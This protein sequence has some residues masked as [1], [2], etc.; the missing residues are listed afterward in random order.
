[1]IIY[2]KNDGSTSC[3]PSSI[4]FGSSLQEVTVIVPSMVATIT[5]RIKPPNA[6][7]LQPFICTPTFSGEGSVVFVA[8]LE[9][10]MANVSGRAEYQV[11]AI[12]PEGQRMTFELGTF[13][14][15][16][17]VLADIPET[18]EQLQDYNVD[19]LYEMLSNVTMVY[20]AFKGIEALVGVGEELETEAKTIIEAINEINGK[21]GIAVQLPI[22]EEVSV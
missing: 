20:E 5:L 17:G 19:A 21:G 4:P 1:M 3:F 8:K 15:A 16:R 14:I 2:C 11:E 18:P 10:A 9:K 22:A 13:N 6:K 7:Y 12:T